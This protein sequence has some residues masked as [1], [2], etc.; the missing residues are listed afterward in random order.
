MQDKDNK[1]E[2][3]WKPEGVEF[4]KRKVF[5]HHEALAKIGGY[6]PE[7]GVKTVGHR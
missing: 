4:A 1:V 7:R 2:R 3:T 6:D 5:A